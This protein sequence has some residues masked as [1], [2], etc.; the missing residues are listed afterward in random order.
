MKVFFYIGDVLHFIFRY[1]VLCIPL[2]NYKSKNTLGPLSTTNQELSCYDTSGLTVQSMTFTGKMN[3]QCW[4]TI[5]CAVSAHALQ[6]LSDYTVRTAPV[7]A[8]LR[9]F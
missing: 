5:D 4:L 6:E 8:A 2:S 3:D 1:L 7:I 9:T